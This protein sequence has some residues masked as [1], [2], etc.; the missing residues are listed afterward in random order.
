M[1][2]ITQLAAIAVLTALIA[3]ACSS[4]TEETPTDTTPEA[5]T[6]GFT[7]NAKV[8]Y[9]GGN[10]AY[11][12]T[13]EGGNFVYLDTAE[14]IDRSFSFSGEVESPEMY[15]ITFE[16]DEGRI[17]IFLDNNDISITGPDLNHKNIEISGSDTHAEFAAFRKEDGTF[18]EQLMS[19]IAGFRGAEVSGSEQVMDSLDMEYSRIDSLRAVFVEGYIKSHSSSV[20]TSYVLYSN[21]YR[22]DDDQLVE[23]FGNFSD[24]VKTTKYGK[25][26]SG[27]I[28]ALENTKIGKP[29]PLFTMNDTEGNAVSLDQFRGNY[30]L[31]DFWASWCGPCREENPNIVAA[32]NKHKDKGFQIL[33]VSLDDAE[34][35]WLAAIQQDGLP[36]KHVSDLKGWKNAAA[37]MYAVQS[38]PQSVLI[39]KDGVIVAKNL[40]GE[41]LQN[42]L[43]D[44]YALEN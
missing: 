28:A 38:I 40:R 17:D 41:E 8:D 25:V 35:K 22:F 20:V 10:T 26:I 14:I 42:T 32:Y 21:L 9:M 36:W 13:F 24:D 5:N 12:T 15:F 7:I 3:T 23:L 31:I 6:P 34:G 39:D 44:L 2:R 43:D 37:K 19:V 1:K 18:D 27:V 4:A 11:L 33:G 16:G 29:A 30:L